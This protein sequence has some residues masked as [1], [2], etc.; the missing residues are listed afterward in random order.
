MILTDEELDATLQPLGM[1]RYS[2]LM[3]PADVNRIARIVEQAVL[4][5]LR[6]RPADAWLIVD[7]AD[8]Y[9]CHK[10]KPLH[11]IPTEVNE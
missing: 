2:T 6:E 1:A 5:K 4:R 9:N 8:G 11:I 3:G 10:W 7:G